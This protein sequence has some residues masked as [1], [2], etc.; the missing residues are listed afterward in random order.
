[1]IDILRRYSSPVDTGMVLME[2]MHFS[3]DGTKTKIDALYFTRVHFDIFGLFFPRA[4]PSLYMAFHLL[5]N[6]YFSQ[7]LTFCVSSIKS[8]LSSLSSSRPNN[9]SNCSTISHQVHSSEQWQKVYRQERTTLRRFVFCI[10]TSQTR[11]R[12]YRLC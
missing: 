6:V 9:H 5:I 11:F 2:N 1:M 10:I 12:S 8:P 4:L 7:N 3:E